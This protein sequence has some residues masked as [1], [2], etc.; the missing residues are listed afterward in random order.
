M[1]A[2]LRA[3]FVPSL[4]L[5]A[6]HEMRRAIRGGLVVLVLGAAGM[7]LWSAWAPLSGA[8]IA[9]GFVKVDMNRKVV[10]HQEGG[11]VKEIKVRDGDRVA[12]GQPLIVLEDVRVDATFDL[13]RQQLESERAKSARLESERTLAPRVVFPADLEKNRVTAR[14]AEVL[15][16]EVALFRARRDALDSQIA[17]LRAQIT[18]GAEEAKAL[19][20]QI[21]AEERAIRL[22]REELALNEKLARDNFIQRSR[23]I[24]LERN[25][26]E[27]EAR[28]GEHRAE[29]SKTRQ[30]TSE[31]ELRI[32]SMRNSYVQAATDEHKE[33]TG[34]IY[35]L[36]ER[37]RPSKD[38][39]QRQVI[40]SPIAGEVVGLKVFSSGSVIG[41]REVLLEVV[42]D[43]KTLIV[44]ARIRPEDINHVRAGG[45]ADVRL[46]AYHQRTTP[47]VQ[48][49]ITYVSGDRLVEAAGAQSFAYYSV[50][51][52]VP[53]DALKAAGNLR[54]SAGMPAEVFIRTDQRT[55]F[56]YLIAP[57]TA[58]FRRG[59]REPL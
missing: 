31:I 25:L 12:R 43:E 21:A 59:M 9:Q 28:M 20:E 11:I 57:I 1:M 47:M 13:L 35:D 4:E 24:A 7:A 48:G 22:A 50:H 15:S 46:T 36:E 26:A 2:K 34:R 40:M 55:A 3:W 30:R 32:L 42:P 17:L 41:P 37:L 45:E 19:A 51:I 52:D 29:L 49:R 18:E 14:S 53:L 5:D 27:Y 58:Y 44:E 33:S 39:A 38:A 54:M 8:V 16:R 10:Q 56:D 23:L 6:G